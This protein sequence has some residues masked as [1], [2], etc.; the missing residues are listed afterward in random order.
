MMGAGDDGPGVCA[1]PAGGFAIQAI[2]GGLRARLFV[3]ACVHMRACVRVRVRACVRACVRA[4]A[5]VCRRMLPMLLLRQ[6][7]RTARF[8]S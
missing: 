6:H 3:R 1:E 2:R 8:T 5:C 4:G 7:P